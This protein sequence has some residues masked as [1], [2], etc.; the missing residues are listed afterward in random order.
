[1]RIKFSRL[2][3]DAECMYDCINDKGFLISEMP[4]ADID[5]SIKN[6]DGPRSPRYG[7]T[8]GDV[9]E[10]SERYSCECKKYVGGAFEGKIC[11]KCH[12]KVEFR[13]MDMNYFGYI[14]LS[15]YS[16]I[17]PKQYINV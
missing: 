8:F 15:P 6:I 7:S 3:L 17:N 2:N 14:N 13:D 10:F 12:T 5:K 1:M 4:Y 16:I 11:E 9:S